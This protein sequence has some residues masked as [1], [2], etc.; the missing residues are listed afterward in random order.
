MG[1][2][3]RDTMGYRRRF[4]L[5]LSSKSKSPS[6]HSPQ[7]DDTPPLSSVSNTDPDL[8]ELLKQVQDFLSPATPADVPNPTAVPGP[9]TVPTLAVLPPP[10]LAHRVSARS[11]KK[12]VM[13]STKEGLRKLRDRSKVLLGMFTRASREP[14][15]LSRGLVPERDE[16]A[17][18]QRR[19]E[20]LFG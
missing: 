6:L 11:S 17:E 10:V 19:Y 12:G 9:S 14:V 15:T 5:L 2:D 4:V 20:D 3:H 18:T 16:D 8:R 1:F 13:A 7:A